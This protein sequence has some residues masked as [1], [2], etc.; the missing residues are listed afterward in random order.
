MDDIQKDTTSVQDLDENA[1]GLKTVPPGLRRGLRLPG[2]DAETDDNF[3]AEM[4]FSRSSIGGET[5]VRSQHVG[6]FPWAR[7]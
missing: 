2:D 3:M 5:P 6:F 1:D 7:C 4:Q